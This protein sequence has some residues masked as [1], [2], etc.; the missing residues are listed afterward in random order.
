MQREQ[1]LQHKLEK[2]EN[3]LDVYWKQRAKV[4]WL[5][6][7]D[8]NIAFFTHMHRRERNTIE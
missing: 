4:N 3:Q 2:L 5:T 8:K 6:K 7:G 1:I